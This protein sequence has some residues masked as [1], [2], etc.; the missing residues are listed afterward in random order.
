M[1]RFK[2]FIALLVITGLAGCGGTDDHSRTRPTAAASIPAIDACSLLRAKEV[3]TVLKVPVHVHREGTNCSFQGTRAHVFRAVL[4]SPESSSIGGA[5]ALD[6]R[7]GTMVVTGRG[8][9][10]VAQNIPPSQSEGGLAQSTARIAAGH[11]LVYLLVTFKGP[12][13]RGVPQL[14]EAVELAK[15]AG[16][17]LAAAS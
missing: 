14:H 9:R 17:R 13:L 16:P 10:G 11:S 7:A 8:Y 3:S 6:H 5:S 12:G 4:V 2:G 1:R 15:R